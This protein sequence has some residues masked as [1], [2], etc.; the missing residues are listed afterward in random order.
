ML[1]YAVIGRTLTT[2]SACIMY[3]AGI[4]YHLVLPFC[5][6]H[7]VNNQTL[8]P[9]VYPTNSAF[10]Q[11][12]ISPVYEIMYAAHC[13][14]GYTLYSVTAGTCGLAAMFATHACGQIQMIVIRLKDAV[15]G[16]E[17]EPMPDVSQRLAAIVKRHV[18]VTR[19]VFRQLT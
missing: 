15:E 18:Q 8:R 9:L 12:Q 13:L 17:F 3:T 6:V 19:S 16:K 5:S 4:I 10:R 14:C 2:W 7:V 11:S 1:K